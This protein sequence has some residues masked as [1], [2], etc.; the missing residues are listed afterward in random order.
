MK[1]IWQPRE[2]HQILVDKEIQWTPEDIYNGSLTI[3][4]VAFRNN[5]SVL[6]LQGYIKFLDFMFYLLYI[7]K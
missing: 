1:G 6:L 2:S 4:G 7:S 5:K 3:F